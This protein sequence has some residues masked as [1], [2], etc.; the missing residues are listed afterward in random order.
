M[1]IFVVRV[2]CVGIFR[3]GIHQERVWWVGTLWVGVFQGVI[4]KFVNTYVLVMKFSCQNETLMLQINTNL[5]SVVQLIIN[6]KITKRKKIP[7]EAKKKQFAFLNVCN[8]CCT[9]Y[10]IRRHCISVDHFSNITGKK[11]RWGNNFRK[12]HN[13][14]YS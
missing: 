13:A 10:V 11:Q 9:S 5:L 4:L 3:N 2:L 7:P 1:I 12:K 14:K 6:N 8:S